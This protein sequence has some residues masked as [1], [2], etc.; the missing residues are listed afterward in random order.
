MNYNCNV[1]C[2]AGVTY[3][4]YKKLSIFQ[5]HFKFIC[6]LKGQVLGNLYARHEKNIQ[7]HEIIYWHY[8]YMTGPL[9]TAAVWS[10]FRHHAAVP[11]YSWCGRKFRSLVQHCPRLGSSWLTDAE[12]T[13]SAKVPSAKSILYVS[14][15]DTFTDSSSESMSLSSAK[16][17]GWGHR[18]SPCQQSQCKVTGPVEYEGARTSTLG[19]SHIIWNTISRRAV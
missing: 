10:I 19:D 8:N 17:N 2:L 12:H 18:P 1:N 16:I 14:G 4:N 9:M 5:A 15:A 3:I 13:R 11:R 6:Q 7:V